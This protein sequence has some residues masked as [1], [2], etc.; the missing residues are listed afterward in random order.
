MNAYFYEDSS[1]EIG[2]IINDV[3]QVTSKE[4]KGKNNSMVVINQNEEIPSFIVTD[5]EFVVGD[6]IP[7]DEKN[8]VDNYIVETPEERMK[9]IEE[10]LLNLKR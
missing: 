10:S 1:R 3:Q 2:I 8:F 4:I 9:R 5:R 6:I 7:I